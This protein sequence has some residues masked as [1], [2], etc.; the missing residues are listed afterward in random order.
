[1]KNIRGDE[2]HMS[3]RVDVDLLRRF[4]Y[5]AKYNDRSMNGMILSL[6]RRC[7][8]QFEEKNGKIEL[9]EEE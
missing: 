2:K 8:A 7:V 5:V 6:M 4:A 1:M 9:P 3:L